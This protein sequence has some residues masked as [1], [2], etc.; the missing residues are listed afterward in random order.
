MFNYYDKQLSEKGFDGKKHVIEKGFFTRG[1]KVV[2][3]GIRPAATRLLQRN[4]VEHHII[5]LN[6]LQVLRMDL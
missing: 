6:L 1:N 2:I 3:T 5:L 4:I